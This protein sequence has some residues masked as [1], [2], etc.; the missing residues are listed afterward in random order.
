M[1][2]R[3]WLQQTV[4]CASPDPGHPEATNPPKSLNDS[5]DG[6]VKRRRKFRRK[7]KRER[8]TP[9]STHAPSLLHSNHR[10][11]DD[12]TSSEETDLTRSDSVKSTKSGRVSD[13][14]GGTGNLRG[15][16]D[17]RARRKTRAD[18]YEPNQRRT[19]EVQSAEPKTATKRIKRRDRRGRDGSGTQ[20]LVQSFQLKNGPKKQRLTVSDPCM[21]CFHRCKT[22]FVQLPTR[23]NLG[24]FKHGRASH[25]TSGCRSGCNE[26]FLQSGP[27]HY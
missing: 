19:K 9:S 23:N 20:D 24:I 11:S 13:K 18:R 2:V 3:S 8:D 26:T 7:R 12:D 1:D 17:R 10:F 16:Y 14:S 21:S 5:P 15:P 4:D 25:Q 6:D 22:D 27:H